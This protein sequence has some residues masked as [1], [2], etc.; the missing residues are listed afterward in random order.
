MYRTFNCGVGMVLAVD[1][2]DAEE[3]LKLLAQTGEAAFL[4]GHIE[5][6]QGEAEVV[7]LA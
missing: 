2:K 4:I 6:H 7:I 5:A 1:P 3:T